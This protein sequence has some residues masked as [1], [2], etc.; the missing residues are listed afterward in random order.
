MTWSHG[1]REQAGFTIVEVL[2]FLS[3]ALIVIGAV[4]ELLMGQ[5]RLYQ[6]QREL[7]DV[8][9][10]IRAA[11]AVLSWELRQ[12][13]A[14][15]GDLYSIGATSFTVRSIQGGG[16]ICGEHPSQ[17]RYG[18][19]GTWG[20]FNTAAGDS[21]LVFAAGSQGPDDD[22][23]KVVS[24]VAV[25][26]AASGGVPTC[27]WGDADVGKGRGVGSGTGPSTWTGNVTPDLVVEV[28]G[29]MDSVYMGAPF[30]AFRP[31]EFG[32][33]QDQGRWWLGRRVGGGPYEI[34]T[35]PLRPPSDSGLVFTYFDQA[36][37]TTTDPSKVALVQIVTRG[38]SF[39]KVP[40][41]GQAPSAE[42]DT[43][44]IRVKLRG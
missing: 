18:L 24:V 35:G 16:V 3:L 10:N 32:L 36:G 4:Y 29:D 6:K 25:L 2:V 26:G 9:S 40:R 44:T 17:L 33:F 5:N 43:L 12:A 37:S 8:R 28:A 15:E 31:V 39:G 23:W 13:S 19:W 30:R 42:Q 27:F 11:A 14:R 38:E 21:A 1:R 20:E 34:L 41:R 7:I 22:A